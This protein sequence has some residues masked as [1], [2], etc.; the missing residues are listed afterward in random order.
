MINVG[1]VRYPGSNCD[2]ETLRYFS[3]SNDV[4]NINSFYIWHNENDL[5]IL[6]NLHL[7]VL[8]GGFAFGDRIY[9]K[10]TEKYKISPGTMALKSP[11]TDIIKKAVERGI[12]I[13]GICNGFQI[14]TKLGLLP[15]HLDLNDCKTFNCDKIK[16]K[17]D[18]KNIQYNTTLCIA[19]S[20]GKFV[21]DGIYA[22][23]KTSNPPIYHPFLKYENGYIAGICDLDKKVFG[24]MPHPERNN[25][26]FKHILFQI[27]LNNPSLNSQMKFDKAIKDL[28][29]S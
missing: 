5:H 11:V 3:Y 8:P 1:I 27:L 13:L 20:Y 16:C 4:C 10:A 7:L 2:I 14:L 22:F 21:P 17:L 24:M 12:P 6:E 28:M 29:Y 26:D 25:Y 18:Y 9:D 19:N 23:G 15:G